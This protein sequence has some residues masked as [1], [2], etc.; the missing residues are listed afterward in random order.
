[1][2]TMISLITICPHTKWL[3][4]YLPCSFCSI[5]HPHELFIDWCLGTGKFLSHYLSK[6]LLIWVR[7][8]TIP[9]AFMANIVRKTSWPLNPSPG[10]FS[11]YDTGSRWYWPSGLWHTVWCSGKFSCRSFFSLIWLSE[12]S[13]YH[14][15]CG[16]QQ[17]SSSRSF[18]YNH[19]VI[20]CVCVVKYT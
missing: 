2:L 13:T 15:P 4:Y 12:H 11:S 16:H 18:A 1:M 9:Q 19:T 6:W 10:V 5:L 14:V 8:W 7:S 17:D 20:L 3:Q